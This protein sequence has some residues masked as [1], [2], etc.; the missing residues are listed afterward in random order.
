METVTTEDLARLFELKYSDLKLQNIY[1]FGSRL[2][3]C[4]NEQSDY[5]FIVLVEG[6]Y[7][8]GSKLIETD[9]VNLNIYHLDYFNELLK[10]NIVWAI[11]LYYI[12]PE[13]IFQEN[14]KLDFKIRIPSLKKS[15]LMDASHNY[16][17]AKRLW[18]ANDIKKSK[19]NIV[20]GLRYL[21]LAKQL[22]EL[23]KIVDFTAGNEFWRELMQNEWRDWDEIENKF[24]PLYGDLMHEIKHSYNPEDI[25]NDEEN[26]L[27]S[28][29][30]MN[31]LGIDALCSDFSITSTKHKMV[32]ELVHLKYDKKSSPLDQA[33]VQECNGLVVD[34]KQLKA[35]CVPPKKFFQ[36]NGN[37]KSMVDEQSAVVYEKIDGLTANLYFYNDKWHVSTD[38]TADGSEQIEIPFDFSKQEYKLR[39]NAWRTTEFTEEEKKL[40]GI[41]T[42]G[43]KIDATNEQKKIVSFSELFWDA[44]AKNGY[45]LPEDITKCYFFVLIS[46]HYTNVCRYFESIDQHQPHRFTEDT[47]LLIGCRNLLTYDEEA[48]E[49]V[50]E[51]QGWQSIPSFSYSASIEELARRSTE[52]NPM[53]SEGFVVCD[54][55]FNRVKVRSPQFTALSELD[56]VNND[57]NT[58]YRLMIDLIRSNEHV[59]CLKH[60]TQLQSLYESTKLDYDNFCEEFQKVYDS[61]RFDVNDPNLDQKLLARNYAA[62]AKKYKYYQLLFELRKTNFSVTN[63]KEYLRKIRLKKIIDLLREIKAKK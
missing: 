19:K 34:V 36:H 54:S 11:M 53:C 8:F 45:K 50:A 5:D 16:A 2:Y 42:T 57:F 52:L 13:F 58:N 31:R 37:L 59:T 22:L 25:N 55:R 41:S 39:W 51:K 24:K 1:L 61:V 17:K 30:Y 23:E 20:H 38:Y 18:F 47:L 35:V 60:F 12:P 14:I 33:I 7:F 56:L 46:K 4:H 3:K 63:V 48:P 40:K 29:A 6:E 27:F 43:Q 28:V 62:T 44:W 32:N 15:T 10:E 21:L 9:L 49:D 26:K